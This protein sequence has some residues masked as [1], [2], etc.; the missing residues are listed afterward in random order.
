M[1]EHNEVMSETFDKEDFD[2][3]SIKVPKV[4]GEIK[5]CGF[6]HIAVMDDQ[7]FIRPTKEQIKNLHDMLCID[8]VM[9]DEE[10]ED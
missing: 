4:I 10:S 5:V 8:V 7:D 3:L 1:A 6:L 2:K 9:F